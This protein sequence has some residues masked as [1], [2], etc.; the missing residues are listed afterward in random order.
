MYTARFQFLPDRAEHFLPEG[1]LVT[2]MEFDN[3]PEIV[4]Y[5]QE[6]ADAI[7]STVVYCQM[8]GQIVDLADFTFNN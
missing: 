8:N 7:A 1:Q 5:V 6:F 4:S 3:I 2:E